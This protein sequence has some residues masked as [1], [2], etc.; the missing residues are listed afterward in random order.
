[1]KKKIQK[2][3]DVEAAKNGAKVET[4]D[5][6]SV[7]IICYDRLG[8]K[9]PIV[10]LVNYKSSESCYTYTIGGNIY[11]N[12]PNENDLVIIEEVEETKFNVGD[13]ITDGNITIQ[14]EAVKNDCYYYGDC[15]LYSTKVADKVYHL[16]TLDDAKPG[17]V[18]VCEDDKR[19]FIFKGFFYSS[20]PTAYCGID[21]TN[22]IRI[23]TSN[24]WTTAPVRPA[25]S[26]EKGML[27]KKMEEE[28]YKWDAE[29][30]T[31]SKIQRWRDDERAQIDG[32][33]I[34]GMSQIS[35]H[36]GYNTCCYYN[37]FATEKQVKSA[38]AMARISQIMANDERFGGV[39]TDNEWNERSWYNIIRVKKVLI[40]RP[41]TTYEFLAFHTLEQADLFLEENKD[42][43]KDYYMMD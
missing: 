37:L 1:M 12:E 29:S 19:P 4:R 40:V 25:T 9:Y 14:I 7:R 30:L 15:V 43:I 35:F 24:P 10:A 31:L 18:L 13:W 39:V 16:W 41:Q 3:F 42:L 11:Y 36:P 34:N 5:G 20:I 27:F 23:G 8:S 17:D 32:Y 22:S 6:D 21:A 38:L 2:P 28:G 33:F 26:N